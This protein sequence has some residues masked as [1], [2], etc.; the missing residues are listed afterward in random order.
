MAGSLWSKNKA[1][2][3]KGLAEKLAEELTEKL[4]E[5]TYEYETSSHAFVSS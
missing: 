2:L 1:L 4:T 3:A 5:R